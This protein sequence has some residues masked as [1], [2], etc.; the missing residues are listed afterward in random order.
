MAKNNGSKNKGSQD[1]GSEKEFSPLDFFFEMVDAIEEDV[2]QLNLDEE[3]GIGG[4]EC[5]FISYSHLREYCEAIS[6]SFEQIRDQYQAT[7]EE[8]AND[9]FWNFELNDEEDEVNELMEFFRLL[10]TVEQAMEVFEKRCKETGETFDEWNCVLI[11]Y[12]FLR[13][14]GDALEISYEDMQKEISLLHAEMD[15]DDPEAGS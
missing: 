15:R 9:S 10:E 12:S 1:K 5:L 13:K 7:Q 2:T 6:L 8:Q 3:E 4:Y 11:L 14:F